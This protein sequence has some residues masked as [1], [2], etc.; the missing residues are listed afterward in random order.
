MIG[1]L[2]LLF[3][4]FVV[5]VLVGRLMLILIFV[6]GEVMNCDVVM[7]IGFR[8]LLLLWLM[9]L[10]DFVLLVGYLRRNMLFCVCRLLFW[11]GV[12]DLVG[13]NIKL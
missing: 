5:V 8:L 1:R 6:V 2:Y 9:L 13:S 11:F 4:V 7:F 12:N 3:V 10:I